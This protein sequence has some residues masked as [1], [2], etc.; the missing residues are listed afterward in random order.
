[1]AFSSV[2]RSGRLRP[3]SIGSALRDDFDADTSDVDLLIEFV[4]LPEGG[5]ADAYFGLREAL[6]AP[7]GR[8]VDLVADS[9]LRNPY[10]TADVERTRTLL[11]AA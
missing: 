8:E 3:R 5:Y 4:P 9:A 1:M 7:P 10:V 11:Y 6:E 2:R